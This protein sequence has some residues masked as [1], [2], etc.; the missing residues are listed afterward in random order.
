M[1]G[2]HYS[3]P[4]CMHACIAH[5]LYN[6]T[7]CT[8]LVQCNALRITC[9]VHY[10]YKR[11]YAVVFGPLF[12]LHCIM[13]T[14]NMCALY[15]HVQLGGPYYELGAQ[16]NWTVPVALKLHFNQRMHA[17]ILHY[18][19]NVATLYFF[20]PLFRLHCIMLTYNMCALYFYVQECIEI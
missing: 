7:H 17:Y 1:Q 2:R 10:M 9:I 12:R 15:F 13:H 16:K 18:M 6:V 3:T 14:Y 8:L 5:Y 20:G 11:S 19:Y 4:T